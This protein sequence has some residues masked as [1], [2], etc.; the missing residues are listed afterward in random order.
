[1]LIFL[2]S[3]LSLEFGGGVGALA[4]TGPCDRLCLRS[5]CQYRLVVVVVFDTT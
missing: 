5:A 3:F 4:R 2:L 1:M